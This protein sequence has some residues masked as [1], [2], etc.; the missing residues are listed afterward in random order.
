MVCEDETDV[1]WTTG[2]FDACTSPVYN[3]PSSPV[4]KDRVEQKPSDDD[5]NNVK[6]SPDL[7]RLLEQGLASGKLLPYKDG[8]IPR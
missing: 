6:P 1:P 8:F 5:I 4:V 7:L 3:W 2:C